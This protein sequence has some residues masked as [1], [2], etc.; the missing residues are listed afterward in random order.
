[1][2]SPER[3]LESISVTLPFKCYAF[4]PAPAITLLRKDKSTPVQDTFEIVVFLGKEEFTSL[5][6]TI[7]VK[8]NH[9]YQR[10]YNRMFS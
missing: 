3:E 8:I 5:Q 9:H 2:K 7:L 1:P 6:K 10:N 4:E